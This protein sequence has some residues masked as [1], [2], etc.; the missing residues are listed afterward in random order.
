MTGSLGNGVIDAAKDLTVSWQVNGNSAMVGY[1]ISIYKNDSASTQVYS[2]GKLTFGCPFYGVD[3]TGN[4]QFFSCTI[5]ARTLS[6]AGITNGESY[7]L[8]IKQ[9]W[10]ESDSQA[11]TQTSASAFIT[12]STPSVSIAAIPS[13]LTLKEYSFTAVYSQAQGD[14]LSWV[15]WK[16]ALVS[17]SGE[18]KTLKDTGNIYGTAQLQFDYDGFF[19]GSRYAVACN[20]QT[21]NGVEASTGWQEFSVEYET[22][23]LTGTLTATPNRKSNGVK[24]TF[25]TV[26]NI[27]AEITGSYTMEDSYLNLPDGSTAVWNE[28]NGEPMSY[29]PPL[30]V[31]W[32]GKGNA[33]GMILKATG[34]IY[35]D[36]Q[37]G[38]LPIEGSWD[39][40]CYGNGKFVAIL[41]DSNVKSSAAHSTDGVNWTIATLPEQ[42]SWSSVCYGNGKFVAVSRGADAAYSTD[43]ITWTASTM[44]SSSRWASVCY[45]NGKFVAVATY[46][47]SYA[48]TNA[49][50]YSTDGIAWTTMDMPSA[51]IWAA[52]CYGDEKFVAIPHNSDVM[53]YS[54]DG[55]TWTASSMPSVQKWP[56]VCYGSDKFVAISS[57]MQAYAYSADGVT[58][59]E[60]TKLES[61]GIYVCYG[62][63]KYIILNSFGYSY[64]VDGINW[65]FRDTLL[66]Q[67]TDA[68]YGNGSF[69]AI[70]RTAKTMAIFDEK[71]YRDDRFSVALNDVFR[72]SENSIP[73]DKTFQSVC[74]GNGKFVSVADA[75][76]S[77]STSSNTAA[78]SADGSVW[79]AVDMP[80][81]SR[82]GSVCY[83]NGKFVAVAMHDSSNAATN[84]AAYSI[85]GVSWVKAS[86]PS[87][88]YWGSVCYGNGKF[89]AVATYDSSYAVTNAA[90]YSMNGITWTASTMP[91]SSRWA[92][93]CYGNGKFVA[94]SAFDTIAAY[95]VDGI[96]WT[97][98]SMPSNK[99][100]GSVCY[101]NGKF[102]AVATSGSSY[103]T[104]DAAAYS[105]DGIAWTA[106]TMPSSRTWS[107]VC[108]G[109]GMFLAV[110]HDSDTAAIA[111]SYDGA[112]WH[113]GESLNIGSTTS[114][115]YG[116]GLFVVVGPS[117]NAAAAAPET[118]LEVK[119]DY[120][121][122]AAHKISRRETLSIVFGEN[123]TAFSSGESI[124]YLS[125]S[126]MWENMK[127][128]E[129]DGFQSCDYLFVSDGALSDSAI[130]SILT[131]ASYRPDNLP[132]SFFA[133]FNGSTNGG[134]VGDTNISA[135]AIYRRSGE[136]EVLTHVIDTSAEDGNI[137]IDCGAV[138]GKQYTYY[139]YGIGTSTF[140]S[141]ALISSSVTPCFWDWA[142]LSCTT[143]TNGVYHPQ[144]IF[145]FSNNV[146][147]G[148]VSNNNSPNVL[149]NF[150]RYPTV[151]SSPWN[152]R[153]GTL[154]SL[155]GS[156]SGGKYCDSVELRNAIT[157]LSTT[158]RALFLKNRKGDLIK[159]ALSG[160]IEMETMDNS[161]QQAQTMKLPWV[162]I[163]DADGVS[164]VLTQ[165][166][167]A[168]VQSL[169]SPVV[170]GCCGNGSGAA[171]SY[172]YPLTI[173]QQGKT[174]VYDGS[175]PKKVVIKDGGG[176]GEIVAEDD[177]SGNITIY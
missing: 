142:L 112:L 154:T 45:G 27:P 54:A 119:E 121:E 33:V 166:D 176:S 13:P 14:V 92:S 10:G 41:S 161:P 126:P 32:N 85:D 108:Y 95:S 43:G 66:G 157:E 104:T 74:Y 141:S 128:L 58:W 76:G 2:T 3:Y 117:G 20:I 101:G 168:W 39:S 83:G 15:Q 19:S 7:K 34:S 111:F 70:A 63:G 130:N 113:M 131:D 171:T 51:Q 38:G 158:S 22:T 88:K 55:I 94:T 169:D 50:A 69:A 106:S 174:T 62:N 105:T 143:D 160:A 12:R 68:V 91:S 35:T 4:V 61:D 31:A 173:L 9:W 102:V 80:S 97:E 107:G 59:T 5:T 52:V 6:S 138:T 73:S 109:N 49:A 172:A 65:E 48:V 122:P 24:L 127:S 164:I 79:T 147:S 29:D 177:G 120:S 78:Y 115:C 153:S 123:E 133:D 57:G 149:Q 110:S 44:P 124:G 8:T 129:L 175:E 136:D 11:V 67:W 150:T 89:V 86:M 40:V 103:S 98:T 16:L 162:E 47:S 1:Q 72:W 144:Q 132:T 90:A 155:I 163:G 100:W 156:V 140:E 18:H 37:Y 125:I 167:G 84:A 135:F 30:N 134:G 137:L 151:Q 139:A 71:G 17:E 26:T 82:W 46:D 23:P 93:V 170:M 28:V 116:N 145:L 21:Q 36:I 81:S 56:S 77:S 165:N 87:N 146:S 64:S 53:A 148:D 25:P 96:S 99:Y 60:A 75:S 42:A 152:Y 118:Y 114:V 159:I